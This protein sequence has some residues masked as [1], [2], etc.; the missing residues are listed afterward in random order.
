ML[1]TR[2]GGHGGEEQAGIEPV[3]NQQ[4][5]TCKVKRCFSRKEGVF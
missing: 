4:D 2:K 1:G 3:S 5:G